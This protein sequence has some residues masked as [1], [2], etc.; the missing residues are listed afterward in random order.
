[1]TSAWDR[2]KRPR[3]LSPS[4]IRAYKEVSVFRTLRQ[5]RLRAKDYPD[6]G[7]LA[8]ELE[9]PAHV[10]ARPGVGGHIGL[11]DTTPSQLVSYVVKIVPMVP[12]S[13]PE[14]VPK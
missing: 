5:L 12:E 2:G 9:V 3:R 1:M 6:I 11:E 14:T 8:A 7:R 4:Q 10:R 13:T